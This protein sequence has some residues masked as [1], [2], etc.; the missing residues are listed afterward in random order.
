MYLANATRADIAYAV[1]SASGYATSPLK[2]LWISI[3]KILKYINTTQ[4]HGL[5]FSKGP[6]TIQ[7]YADSNFSRDKMTENL[8]PDGDSN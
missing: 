5:H 7:G 2:A 4:N 3:Q 1:N 6:V 8:R